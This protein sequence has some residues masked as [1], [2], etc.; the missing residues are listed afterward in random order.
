M[1]DDRAGDF[2]LTENFDDECPKDCYPE[3]DAEPSGTRLRGACRRLHHAAPATSVYRAG[4]VADGFRG[5]LAALRRT[6]RGRIAAAL[7]PATCPGP[8]GIRF[9]PVGRRFDC[10]VGV[11]RRILGRHARRVDAVRRSGVGGFRG[12][13][14]VGGAGGVGRPVAVGRP[15]PRRGRACRRS[16]GRGLAA[17]RLGHLSA[18]VLPGRRHRGRRSRH[19]ERSVPDR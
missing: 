10:R 5:G 15:P 18:R 3:A 14:G 11:A 16:A 13:P 2:S 4:P 6:C 9:R 12:P 17:R 8:R 1:K 7:R 19:H